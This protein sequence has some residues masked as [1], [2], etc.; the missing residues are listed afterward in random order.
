VKES[1]VPAESE[2]N[3]VQRAVQG[4]QAAIVE[5]YDRHVDAIYH[6]V[7]YRVDDD[8]VAKDITSDVFVRALE[9]LSRYEQRDVPFVAWL[10]RIGHA[11]VIDY[12]RLMAHH[13]VVPLD[14]LDKYSSYNGVDSLEDIDHIQHE[15]L[16]QALQHLTDDQQEVIVL[17]FVQGL[18]TVE[19]SQIVG[20]TAGA[21]KALQRR[22]LEALARILSRQHD[23]R[24]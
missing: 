13:P 12:W 23:S 22:G 9:S 1:S 10:Y 16:R 17:R 6:Y 5:L 11:R 15:A 14:D 4:D 20:K 7:R 19:I 21:V 18:S 3:I 24:P 8:E 2:S